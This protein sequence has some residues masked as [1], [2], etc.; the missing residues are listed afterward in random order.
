[1]PRHRVTLL[2]RLLCSRV[3]RASGRAGVRVR[4]HVACRQPGA[5]LAHARQFTGSRSHTSCLQGAK[6]VVLAAAD[7]VT[8]QRCM[9]IIQAASAGASPLQDIASAVALT[10]D[11]IN[12][13]N[14]SAVN[15]V[16]AALGRAAVKELDVTSLKAAGFDA[17]ACAAAGYSW[18][19]VKTAGFTAAEAK[20]AGCN[21][22][23]AK[24]AGYNG[25][26]IAGAFGLDA[27]IAEGCDVSFVL[28]SC[29]MPPQPPQ[30]SSPPTPPQ[31]SPP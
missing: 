15:A 4:D 16:L 30:Q 9:R 19:D 31:P 17:A 29:I 8:R 5:L 3:Q 27:T 26:S 7:D 13:Q 1:M 18:A 12:M 14:L 2:S 11:L 6:E 22:I 24:E 21:F 25:D 20:A 23:S 28:V 10:R